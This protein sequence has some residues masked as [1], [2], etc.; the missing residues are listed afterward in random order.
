MKLKCKHC[1]KPTDYCD[2]VCDECDLK[3]QDGIAL[4]T[5]EL[6]REHLAFCTVCKGGEGSLTTECCSRPMTEYESNR[7][8]KLGTLDYK[9]G[10]WITLEGDRKDE[11]SRPT[12]TKQTA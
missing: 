3:I 11:G 2:R 4:H 6:V 9:D 12:K 8:Y 1:G 5:I 7:V 10:K